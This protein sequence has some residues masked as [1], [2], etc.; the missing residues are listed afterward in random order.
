MYEGFFGFRER[1][2]DLTPNP[3]YLVLTESH[4]E[5]LSNL[6]YGIASRK[7]ITLLIGEAGSGKTTLIRTAIERQPERVHCVHLHNPTL[8]REEFVAMLANRFGLSD[9]AS[10]SKA[11]M[12]IE[13]ETL[14]RQRRAAGEMSVLILDEAQSLPSEL[15]EEIRLL[16]NIETNDEKLMS[17]IIAGQPELADRLNDQSLRQLKQRVALRCQ[18]RPLTLQ[19]TA[20]YIAGRIRA[21]G[22]V[23]AQVFTREAVSLVHERSHGIPRTISVIADNALL[24]GF[25]AGQRPVGSQLVREVCKDFDIRAEPPALPIGPL[26]ADRPFD[27]PVTFRTDAPVPQAPE[28]RKLL[29]GAPIPGAAETMLAEPAAEPAAAAEMFGSATAK[30]K[31]FSFFWN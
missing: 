14:L 1:P 7:G 25:A 22:G 16:A 5:V 8:S 17:V 3:R 20:G 10:R 31:R 11:T 27:G 2:F 21:A 4:R 29:G 13:L 23:G 24:G 12:L 6:E 30:R 28:G 9:E 18:L 19:E 15:L 26:A